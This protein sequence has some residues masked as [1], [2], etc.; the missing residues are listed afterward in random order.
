MAE[1]IIYIDGEYLPKSRAL[2]SV[3]DHGFLYGDGVFEGIRAYNGSIFRLKEH[4]D[5]LYASAKTMM[6]NVQMSK[7]EMEEAVVGTMKKNKL[8]DA[9]IRLIA[10]RGVGDLGLDPRKCSKSTV[11]VIAGTINLMSKEAAENGI[12]TIITWVRRDPIDG[13]SHEVKSL[14]YLNSVLAK[15]E[16]NNVGADEAIFLNPQ[17]YV[18]EGTAENIFAIKNGK[19]LTPPTYTGALPGITK[20]AVTEIAAK[21]GIKV[22]S[23]PITPHELFN[24]EEVFFTGTAAEI[25]PV[26]TINGRVIGDGKAGEITK[27]LR[28]ELARYAADPANG[29]P[30]V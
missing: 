21:M 13:T 10:T 20:I 14:N 11:I 1:Q 4:I 16:A 27:K 24:S 30:C 22:E 5:R 2:I 3:F 6:L 29:T 9:Y 12:K 26:A 25:I 18:C 28:K 15:I 7:G 17:G 8:R 23:R 19:A